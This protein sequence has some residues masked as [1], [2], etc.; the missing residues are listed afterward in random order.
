MIYVDKSANTTVFIGGQFVEQST[1]IA[2]DPDS[3]TAKIWTMNTP[4]PIATL[5]LSNFDMQTGYWGASLD[6]AAYTS[7]TYQVLITFVLAGEGHCI[8]DYLVVANDTVEN[9]YL[10]QYISKAGQG[11]G[12]NEVV[13]DSTDSN[14]NPLEGVQVYFTSDL[15]GN[16]VITSNQYSLSDGTTTWFL[17]SGTYFYWQFKQGNSWSNPQSVVVP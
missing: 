11:N 7:G 1:G 14:G 8:S 5:T 4:T 17:P 16:T 15:A 12:N 10:D 6:I 9:T 13:I 3:A 2:I